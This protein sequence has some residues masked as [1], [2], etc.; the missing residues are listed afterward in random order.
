MTICCPLFRAVMTVIAEDTIAACEE[1]AV[2]GIA[3]FLAFC[4][5]VH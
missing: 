4:C 5:N 1:R 2:Q 3:I